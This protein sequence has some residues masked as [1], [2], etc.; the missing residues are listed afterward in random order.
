MDETL[1]LDLDPAD[2]EVLTQRAEANGRSIEQE[3]AEILHE[4]LHPEDRRRRLLEWSRRIRA[5]TP[6]GIEQ[7]D[8]L[9]LLREDRN[10]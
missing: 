1:K 5:M 3:A 4:H 9:E 10:R 7:T 6:A 8:S 2:R